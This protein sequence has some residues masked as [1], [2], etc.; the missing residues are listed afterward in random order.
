[1][2]WTFFSSPRGRLLADLIGRDPTV[3]DDLHCVPHPHSHRLIHIP[4]PPLSALRA[5]TNPTARHS[6]SQEYLLQLAA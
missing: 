5:V 2:G 6:A 3:A 4:L 1:M